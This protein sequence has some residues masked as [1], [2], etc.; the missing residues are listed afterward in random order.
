[1]PA[2]HQALR[3]SITDFEL[4]AGPWGVSYA[5]QIIIPHKAPCYLAETTANLVRSP[6]SSEGESILGGR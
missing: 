5:L 1:M 4:E 6:G 3:Q 2:C